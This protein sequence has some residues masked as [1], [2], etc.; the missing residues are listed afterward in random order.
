MAATAEF[1]VIGLLAILAIAVGSWVS[2]HLDRAR[3]YAMAVCLIGS[4]GYAWILSGRLGWFATLPA[5][6]VVLWSNLTPILL[7]FTAGLAYRSQ[8]LPSWRR[9]VT[10]GLFAMLSLAFIVTPMLRATLTP[11]KLDSQATW[12]EGVCLQSHPASCGPAAAATLMQ[13]HGIHST[14][15]ALA[16]LCYTSQQGTEPLRLFSGLMAA[17]HSKSVLPAVAS[18]NPDRWAV[19]NQLPNIALVQFEAFQSERPNLSQPIHRLLGPRG[20]G[21]AVVVLGRTDS[22]NWLIADPAFGQ[23][24][25]TSE[26]F[27]DRFTGDAIYLSR[28]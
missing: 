27:R 13:L 26:Q 11:L 14:E 1:Y 10:I 12:R 7:S 5:A 17:S 16:K 3:P 25:W 8:R 9:P 22:G 2:G 6:A 21:H 24:T 15:R 18:P 4:F 23:T 20:E 28:Q 19:Q